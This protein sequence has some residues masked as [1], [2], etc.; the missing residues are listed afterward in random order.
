MDKKE[1][2]SGGLWL[3]IATAVL[4]ASVRLG[5]G[6]YDNPGPGFLAFGAGVLL[7]VLSVA[8][9]VVTLSEKEKTVPLS[10]LWTGRKWS[11]PLLAAVALILYGLILPKLGYLTATG[12]LM[13]VLFYLGK[14]KLHLAIPGALLAALATF[15]LFQYLLKMPLPRGLFGF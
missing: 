13:V 9:L 4:V 14:L 5:L 11:I 6:T 8:L 3:C 12:G 1:I 7:A 10:D 2:I 15:F